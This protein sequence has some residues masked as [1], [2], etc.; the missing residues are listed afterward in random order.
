MVDNCFCV[1]NYFFQE[2][3][4][5]QTEYP[6]E[7]KYLDT[8]STIFACHSIFKYDDEILSNIHGSNMPYRVHLKSTDFR[9]ERGTNR[10]GKCGSEQ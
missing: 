2:K 5:Q 6:S 8:K 1:H 9:T 7:I 4:F 10:A 3:V